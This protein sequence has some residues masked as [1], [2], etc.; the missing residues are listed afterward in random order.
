MDLGYDSLLVAIGARPRVPFAEALTFRGP[1]DVGPM[2]HLLAR[3]DAADVTSVAYVVPS[4]ST[5]PLP[6]YEL[7]LMVAERAAERG[8]ALRQAVLTPEPLPLAVFGQTA[9]AEVARL[10]ASHGIEVHGDVHVR[11][12]EGG[13]V[14]AVPGDVT[15]A[16]DAIVAVPQLHGPGSSGLPH[17]PE[18]FLPVGPDGRVPGFDNVFGAGDG[19]TVAIKQG[20]IAAQQADVAAS[21]IAIRAGAPLTPRTFRPVLRG[22]LLTGSGPRYLR[23]AVTGGA[24]AQSSVA[25]EHALWWPPAKVAAPY[26]APYLNRLVAGQRGPEPEPLAHRLHGAGDPTDGLEVLG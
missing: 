8:L 12:V 20:G 5:W 7:A 21:A 3:I 24:G 11:S 1:F 10:L 16:A 23:D 6:V 13:V 15:V 22:E 4:G 17:D 18:G 9:S 2:T 14:S 26:L 19:T 25:S